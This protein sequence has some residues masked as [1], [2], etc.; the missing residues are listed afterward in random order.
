MTDIPESIYENIKPASD[1]LRPTKTLFDPDRTVLP[2]L[3]CFKGTIT[4]GQET[5]PQ[6]ILICC[7]WSPSIT[8]RPTRH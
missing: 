5:L 2:V 4:R 8:A 3:G 7:R 1:L 6:V